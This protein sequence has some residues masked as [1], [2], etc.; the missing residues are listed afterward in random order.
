MRARTAFGVARLGLT[1][2]ELVALIGYFQYTLGVTT[3]A[4]ANFFSYFT[5]QSAIASIFVFVAAA[6][7]A[8]RRSTD[9]AW[10]DM[11]RAMVT[12]YILV[13]GVVYGII[14]W[15]SSSANYSIE[16]PW[17]SQ[18]LHFVIPVLAL[19]DWIVDPFK[20]R[21]PWR[22]LGWAIVFPVFWLVFTLLRGPIVGWYPYFFLD[23]RQVSGPGET[24]FYCLIIVVIITSIAALLTWITRL[25]RMPH[26]RL[27]Y[28]R[29]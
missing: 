7:V 29:P 9:P 14:V 19:I 20:A 23:A 21:L 2:V 5:V 27:A 15:Q 11:L 22:Y 10:L 26:H 18:L 24:V 12:T 3:F 28:W 17:S 25:K 1:A 8:L 13:S 4:I 16:V 6:V